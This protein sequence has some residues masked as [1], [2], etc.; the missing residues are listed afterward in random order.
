MKYLEQVLARCQGQ[1]LP[2]SPFASHRILGKLPGSRRGGEERGQWERVQPV[3][4][5]T[6]PCRREGGD[7]TCAGGAASGLCCFEGWVETLQAAGE[8]FKNPVTGS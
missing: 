1:M 4:V 3:L 2:L 5:P 7:G 6:T 8:V